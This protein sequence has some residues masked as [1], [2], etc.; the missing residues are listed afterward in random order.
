MV[1]MQGNPRMAYRQ[2]HG[3]LPSWMGIQEA[4]LVE[5]DPHPSESPHEPSPV[6]RRLPEP[7]VPRPR[8]APDDGPLPPQPRPQ[9]PPLPR[10]PRRPHGHRKPRRL[11]RTA[12][13]LTGYTLAALAG[14][15]AHHLSAGLL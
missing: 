1:Q 13:R 15:L 12:W 8:P 3:V 10:R 6:P 2:A 14:A 5:R 4:R 7:V 11:G 9:R